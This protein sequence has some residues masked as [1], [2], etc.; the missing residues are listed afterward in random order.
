VHALG[1]VCGTLEIEGGWLDGKI[2]A[3][4]SFGEE[5]QSRPAWW[6]R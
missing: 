4:T 2:G 1:G 5:A 6:S 3:F